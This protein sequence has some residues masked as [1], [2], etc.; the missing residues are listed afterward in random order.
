MGGD[1]VA[2]SCT[3][4]A[5]GLLEAYQL[6]GHLF[7][8]K[9][10]CASNNLSITLLSWLIRSFAVASI[11]QVALSPS[12]SRRKYTSFLIGSS[13]GLHVL[14]SCQ[15]HAMDMMILGC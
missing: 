6:Q 5:A 7:P 2:R 8:K 9:G 3:A 14:W 15:L 12:T 10:T 4:F 1:V 13:L 11:I